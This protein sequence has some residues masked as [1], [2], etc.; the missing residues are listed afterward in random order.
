M[1]SEAPHA[2]IAVDGLSK[3]YRTKHGT[4]K[5]VDDASFSI[6]VG[7]T[8]AV[9]GESGCGKSTLA[10]ALLGLVAPDAGMMA[11]AGDDLKPISQALDKRLIRDVGVV[12]QNPHSSLNPKMRVRA[13]VGEPLITAFGLRGKALSD[14]VAQLL[15]AV[16]LGPAFMRRFPHELSGGQM[17]RIAIARAL[18]LEPKLL[19]LD[20]PTAALD[21]SVQAQILKLLKALQEETGVSYLF[22]THDLGT[23]DYIADRIVVMYLGRIVES[24]PVADVFVNPRHPYTKAL[25]DAV[26]TI[27]P[28]KRGDITTLRGEIP[29]PLH[30]PK[31]CA[32]S[33][34]CRWSSDQC[35]QE[36]P[37]LQ[38]VRRDRAVACHHPLSSADDSQQNG[39]VKH[40]AE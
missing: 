20:E 3:S 19:I 32:F 29:S 15:G 37:E 28:K 10:M 7:E 18:A 5:A 4:L 16:G 36:E 8:L 6:G 22:I 40:E 23:V 14:R 33:P 38:W 35:R 31:G 12:F 13:I 25:L 2:L 11:I 39:G 24:G 30:R 9:V 26:P 27:D 34:R 17:Q 21:V 1:I